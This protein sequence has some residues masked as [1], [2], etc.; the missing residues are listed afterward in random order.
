MT[1]EIGRDLRKEL[2]ETDQQY[3]LAALRDEEGDRLSVLADAVAEIDVGAVRSLWHQGSDSS[4]G[5][6]S[7]DDVIRGA[8]LPSGIVRLQDLT[9]SDERSLSQQGRDLLGGSRVAVLTV[10]GGQGSRLGFDRPKGMYPIGPVTDRSLFQIFAEQIAALRRDFEAE[11]PWLVMTSD[12]THDETEAYFRANSW[13]SL[14]PDSVHFFRQGSLPAVE[15]STGR[16]LVSPDGG[17]SLSPDG[18]GGVVA[19][20][21][22]SGLLD[23]LEQS[24]ISDIFYHQVDN[25]AVRLCAPVVLGAHA[26]RGADVTTCVV[27]KVSPDERMGVVV[28][29]GGRCRI[30]EYSELTP[31][32]S[33][34]TDNEGRWIFQAGNTAIHVFSVAFLR[35]LSAG[36]GAL[37]LHTAR[38][39]VAYRDTD[40]ST[41]VPESPNAFKFERFIFD[42]LPIAERSLVVEV[43]RA[44]WFAPVKNAEG[45]DSPETSRAALS[46]LGRAWLEAVGRALPA[47]S[48]VEISPLHGLTRSDFIARIRSGD[49]DPD[50]VPVRSQESGTTE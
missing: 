2:E 4:E 13:F 40:G 17:V 15:A 45:S 41:V 43:D 23:R 35:T 31:E 39:K 19:A 27:R 32:Q 26:D 21:S 34:R 9:E 48:L 3:L 44:E 36:A 22:R 42:A 46:R 28:E 6:G 50:S 7:A 16:I 29:S 14:P 10:A 25:P 20:L 30:V 33:A 24:G 11:I 49:V 18:H 37:P 5:A 47:D 12:A 8:A 1:A 38:K